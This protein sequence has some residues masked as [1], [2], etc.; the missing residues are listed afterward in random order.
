MII[1]IV[2]NQGAIVVYKTNDNKVH[3]ATLIRAL[4][5]CPRCITVIPNA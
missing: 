4:E 5:Q 1:R 3:A 2:L